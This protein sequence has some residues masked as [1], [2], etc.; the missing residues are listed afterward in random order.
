MR[1]L[2]IDD[3]WVCMILSGKKTW[4]IR[5]RNTLI[6]ERIA[7]GNIKIKYVV[8]YAK[9]VN[10]VEMTVLE[11]M[12]HSNKHQANDFIKQYAEGRTTLFA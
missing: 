9:I 5:R 10:S 12:K 3:K 11:L 2:K 1:C 4:E 8:G 6:R 7:L